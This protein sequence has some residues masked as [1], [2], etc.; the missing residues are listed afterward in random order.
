MLNEKSY[1]VADLAP[2]VKAQFTYKYDFGDNWEHKVVLGK[3]C[4]RM[5]TSNT[6]SVWGE[7]SPPRP[8]IAAEARAMPSL[9]RRWLIQSTKSTKQM[10]EW[11]GGA[12]DARRFSLETVNILLKRI[13]A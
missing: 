8:R 11:I 3:P 1:T 5:P 2:T 10:E 13:K 7:L 12:W 4:H 6:P 9:W